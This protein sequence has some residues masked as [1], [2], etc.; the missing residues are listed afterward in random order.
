MEAFSQ[1]TW[2]RATSP[3]VSWTGA[4]LVLL[5][6]G[7][8]ICCFSFV[9]IFILLVCFCLCV[10]SAWI[11]LH[12]AFSAMAT[13]QC[14]CDGEFRLACL[15]AAWIVLHSAFSA[16]ATIQ[17][18]CDGFGKSMK[19]GVDPRLELCYLSFNTLL[20]SPLIPC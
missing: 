13:I 12:S 18:L 2:F 5:C 11:V 16:M 3:P 1:R 7:P 6:Q 14:L 4:I 9:C 17:C 19:C 20:Y 10:S 15:C 8:F